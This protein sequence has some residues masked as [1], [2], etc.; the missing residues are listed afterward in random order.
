MIVGLGTDIERTGRF[1]GLLENEGFMTRVYSAVE[2][3]YLA[4]K[5]RMASQSAAGFFCAKEAF[6]KA[7]G[8]GCR[9]SEISVGHRADGKPFLELL[10]QTAG[11]YG[12]LRS[13]LS[14]SHADGYAVATVALE[15]EPSAALPE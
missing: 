2:R 15:T 4:R 10:G 8:P 12:A 5:G 14:I 7:A 11:R 1:T 3:D 6:I 13:H 9:L